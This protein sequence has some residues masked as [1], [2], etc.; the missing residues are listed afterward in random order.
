MSTN[1]EGIY[2]SDFSGNTIFGNL[3]QF[4]KLN[5]KKTINTE[6]FI[7]ACK[8]V[9]ALLDR[10]GAQF[11]IAKKDM[12][13]NVKRIEERFNTNK[14][15]YTTLNSIMEEDSKDS[16][17][18][19]T[20]AIVGI[21]WLKRGLEFLCAILDGLLKAYEK[22]VIDDNLRPIILEAY[23]KTLK[24]YHGMV[25]KFLFSNL[26]R[27]VPSK[28]NFNKALLLREDA[29]NEMLFKDISL[30]LENF[31]DNLELIN[32]LFVQYGLNLEES[33]K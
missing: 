8:D 3:K 25:S 1:T 16:P 5:E 14:S 4:S 15:Q 11:S 9:T 10:L 13:G 12:L 21:L 6:L 32:S 22:K 26:T 33:S 31:K 23:E 19:H 28:S 30:Y 2:M 20:S 27:L 29:T 7:Q 17:K 24:P 18:G